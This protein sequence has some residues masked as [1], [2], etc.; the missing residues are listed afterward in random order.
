MNRSALVF[1]GVLVFGFVGCVAPPP[2]SEETAGEEAD[3]IVLPEGAAAKLELSYTGIGSIARGSVARV[4]DG[5]SYEVETR[6]VPEQAASV[7]QA[8]S[9]RVVTDAES[10]RALPL[11]QAV[12]PPAEASGVA[13]GASV[14]GEGEYCCNEG[15][16][17]C[18][19]IGA[20]CTQRTC[21]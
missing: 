15:C 20:M 10:A 9:S 6:A 2:S 12:D 14:C 18:A 5:V 17:L 16:G 4:R 3:A 7:K 8:D 1:T 13:C 21:E 19:P 11:L